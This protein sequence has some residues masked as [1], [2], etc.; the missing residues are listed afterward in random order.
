[1]D[2]DSKNIASSQNEKIATSL[3]EKL[4]DARPRKGSFPIPGR[5]KVL[6]EFF[7]A[8]YNYFESTSK[9]AAVV[10]SASDWLLDNFY[11]LEQ[12]LRVIEEDL[13]SDYYAR[14]PKTKDGWP[15]IQLLTI[16]LGDQAPRLDL[17]QIKR[18]VQSFQSITTLQVGELWALPLMLRITS[19]ETLA[20]GLAELTK[21][22][23]NSSPKPALWKE[24]KS[25]LDR[26]E[27][28]AE[29]H[30]INSILNLRL[31]ATVEWK[32]FFEETSVL[33]H[34]LQRDPAGVYSQSDF[35]TRN[36]YRSVVEELARGSSMDEF[37]IAREAI[38]LATSANSAR[39]RHVGFYLIAEG[40]SKL[41]KQIKFHPSLRRS[42]LRTLRDHPTFFY[43]GSITLI[44]LVL[45]ASIFLFATRVNGTQAQIMTAVLLA[46]LPASAIA[47]QLVNWLVVL[48][49]P[50]HTLPKLE[51]K[52]GVPLEFR[53]MVVIPA[54][55]GAEKDVTF[56]TRQI[57]NHFVGNKDPNILFA[58]LTDFADAPEKIMPQDEELLT[59]TITRIK[60]LNEIYGTPEYQPFFLF[61]RERLWNPG[62]DSWIGWERKRGKLE[63]FNELLR[64]SSTTTYTTQIGDLRHLGAI[65]YVITLDADTLLP[66]ESARRLVGTLAHV[67]NQAE[68]DPASEQVKAGYTILQP[69]V[70]VRPAVV[71]RSLFTRTYAG[72][73]V[74]DLYS[75]A[76][77]DVYQ[78]LF[79]EGQLCRQG[80]LRCR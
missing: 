5:L 66:R 71:N 30:V 53:T 79:G 29:M 39:E 50:P 14:L 42:I 18:F 77:S 15:R 3:A 61:N 35:E 19:L 59:R 31:I 33:D 9:T 45:L 21:M 80:D 23:W 56:L 41:E 16:A 55:L 7:Q 70:Q 58:L 49:I 46:I 8:A 54:L 72:D 43:V 38:D 12:A 73:A 27:P 34:T 37:E 20:M 11:I 25:A 36:H 51:L 2:Q 24:I 48:I 6:K 60:E 44:T 74:I 47:I 28:D 32:D 75:R 22:P 17:D 65:R 52:N 63:E 4:K 1:M 76:V 57:E 10:S 26:P 78:D 62:E 40:R 13:P 68:Y 67:L 69:R 64:G